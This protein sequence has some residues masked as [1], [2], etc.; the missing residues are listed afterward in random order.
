MQHPVLVYHVDYGLL[1]WALFPMRICFSELLQSIM[2]CF[3]LLVPL[4]L[5]LDSFCC[6]L[7]GWSYFSG[8]LLVIRW[9]VRHVGPLEWRAVPL[10][11]LWPPRASVFTILSLLVS[12]EDGRTYLECILL[13][14]GGLGDSSS[15]S[16]S[17]AG[18]TASS[19][20]VW[21]A[22]CYWVEG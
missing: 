10:S 20:W 21:L 9:R 1:L 5:P 22:F 17:V 16:S 11:V 12:L 15:G 8:S 18:W 19:F 13:L 3:V 2:V 14:D 7:K 6:H 4:V